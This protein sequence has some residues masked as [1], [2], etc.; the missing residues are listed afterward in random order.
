[1]GNKAGCPNCLE[2]KK[3]TEWKEK[4]ALIIETI[5]NGGKLNKQQ[6][7]WLWGNKKKMKEGKLKIDRVKLLQTIQL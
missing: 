7:H 3:E 5:K 6:N 1:M 4:L 2:L